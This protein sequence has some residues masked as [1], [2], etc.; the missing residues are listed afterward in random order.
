MIAATLASI[1]APHTYLVIECRCE[2]SR[3]EHWNLPNG[4]VARD[5]RQHVVA[6]RTQEDVR[7]VAIVQVEG[8]H[9]ADR[10]RAVRVTIVDDELNARDRL[11]AIDFLNRQFNDGQRREERLR[12][13]LG[14]GSERQQHSEMNLARHV[15]RVDTRRV[16]RRRRRT[17]RVVVA[18]RAVLHDTL[19]LLPLARYHLKSIGVLTERGCQRER[20]E[21][22]ECS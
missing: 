21:Q 16:H 8:G 11:L 3:R 19:V 9:W 12:C 4:S 7:F 18:E 15:R 22:H 14:G 20:R 13:S 2:S 17:R 1:S 10:R 5:R 6:D